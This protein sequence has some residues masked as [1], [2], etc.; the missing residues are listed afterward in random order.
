MLGF[1]PVG[2]VFAGAAASW[3]PQHALWVLLSVVFLGGMA[4][5]FGDWPPIEYAL[6]LGVWVVVA[7]L[8][9]PLSRHVPL[10]LIG[11]GVPGAIVGYLWGGNLASFLDKPNVERLTQAVRDESADG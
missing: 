10:V 9:L 6:F 11:I 5:Y 1:V 4:V 7:G 2:A 8:L 3:F